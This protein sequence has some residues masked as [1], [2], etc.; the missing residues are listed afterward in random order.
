MYKNFKYLLLYH[1]FYEPHV[2]DI[3]KDMLTQHI[4]CFKLALYDILIICFIYLERLNLKIIIK[5]KNKNIIEVKL[6]ILCEALRHKEDVS[7]LASPY[8]A[9]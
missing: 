8:L 9:P 7:S 3:I 5:V 1:E 2:M 6:T 4:R